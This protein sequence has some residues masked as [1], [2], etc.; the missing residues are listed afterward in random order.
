M[1]KQII[2]TPEAGPPLGAYSQGVRAGDFVFVTGCGPISPETGALKGETIEEQTEIVLDNMEAILKAAGVTLAD[3][4]KATVHLADP[5]EF[6]RYNE[7]YARRMPEPRP[8]R[9]TV[10]S[11]LSAVENMRVEIDVIAYDG[12]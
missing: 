9:T 2:T 1:G 10:G 8:A 6:P 4:V 3:V 5:S 12:P 11:D 7:V